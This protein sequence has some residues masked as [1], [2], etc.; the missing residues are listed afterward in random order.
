MSFSKM[1]KKELL[2]ERCPKDCCGVSFLFAYLRIAGEL[3]IR[4]GSY[5]FYVNCSDEN[6]KNYISDIAKLSY[7]E[8]VTID[9]E[10][11]LFGS[12][13]STSMIEKFDINNEDILSSFTVKKFLCADCKKW[14][15]IGAFLANGTS[16]ILLNHENESNMHKKN[17]GYSLEFSFF[18]EGLARDFSAFLADFDCITKCTFSNNVYKVYLKDF[19][20]ICDLLVYM[21]ANGAVLKLYEENAYRSLKND[22]NRQ[23]N[24]ISANINKTIDSSMKQYNAIKKIEEKVGLKSLDVKLQTVA[25]LRLENQEDS[26]EEL[27]LKM[28]EKITKSGLNYR[29]NTLLKIANKLEEN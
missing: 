28:E 13:I 24:C 29:L 11:L 12:K 17:F 6:I 5:R 4:E 22:V 14:F 15:L 3:T 18:S 19:D 20:K 21:G 25:K 8:G 16:N 10:G 2:E 1:V 9:E 27:L 26:L 7:D 23:N